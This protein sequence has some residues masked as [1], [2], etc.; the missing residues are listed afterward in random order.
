M[1]TLDIVDFNTEISEECDL[2]EFFGAG[3]QAFWD[4]DPNVFEANV[5]ATPPTPPSWIEGPLVPPRTVTLPPMPSVGSFVDRVIMLEILKEEDPVARAEKAASHGWTVDSRGLPIPPGRTSERQDGKEIEFTRRLNQQQPPLGTA[6]WHERLL[7]VL[8]RTS[9]AVTMLG[10]RAHAL[11]P[12]YPKVCPG[13]F[14]DIFHQIVAG[15]AL[16]ALS[17][18]GR[19]RPLLKDEV[20]AAL[21]NFYSS[22][23]AMKGRIQN[24]GPQLFALLNRLFD[25]EVPNPRLFISPPPI[26]ANGYSLNERS[27]IRRRSPLE[28]W[29]CMRRLTEIEPRFSRN[30]A[31]DGFADALAKLGRLSLGTAC[32]VDLLAERRFDASKPPPKSRVILRLGEW[33][34]ATPGNL[35]ALNAQPKAGKSGVCGAIIASAME[36]KGDCLGFA[37]ENPHGWALIHL[38]CEQSFQDHFSLL[39]T[40]LKRA[41]RTKQPPWLH[42]HCLTDVESA[43]RRQCLPGLLDRCR[44]EHGGIFAV[45]ID[46]IADLCADPN[47]AKE[48]FGLVEELHRFAIEFDTTIICVLHDNA[49]SEMAK[50]RGHLGSQLERKAESNL[51]VQK[52]EHGMSTI[53]SE[54]SRHANIPKCLGPKFRWSA[55]EGMHVPVRK[56]DEEADELDELRSMIRGLF[57]DEAQ[58]TYNDAIERIESILGKEKRTAKGWFTKLKKAGMIEQGRKSA[59]WFPTFHAIC[60]VRL[61][62][63]GNV[64][65]SHGAFAT[66]EAWIGVLPTERKFTRNEVDLI[67]KQ[68]V[69][70]GKARE[71]EQGGW[72]WPA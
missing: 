60:P 66:V 5:P 61:G 14:E 67:A 68:L 65:Q 33:Q 20:E 26:V 39:Q 55:E 58:L 34:I 11:S 53:F 29:L 27:S 23:E 1:T 47:D 62:I 4:V 71:V 22:D 69:T 57:K 31:D 56:E 63:A 51:R 2:A 8:L 24:D 32:T 19:P 52:D 44:T 28:Q 48:A 7:A 37:A 38:D 6:D 10:E 16:S 13:D 46:G 72:V 50:G 9:E 41:Q 17:E 70:T 3:E 40:A 49:G 45:L 64:L 18:I 12:D 15:A 21:Q 35:Q 36:P 59:P 43:T 42:S 54:R 25:G 30:A